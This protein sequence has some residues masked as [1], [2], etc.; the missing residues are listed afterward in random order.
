MM[1]LE[2]IKKLNKQF[3]EDNCIA[4]KYYGTELLTKNGK[5]IGVD[6]M[7][8]DEGLELQISKVI[9][10]NMEDKMWETFAFEDININKFENDYELDKYLEYIIDIY[11]HRFKDDIDEEGFV[12][13]REVAKSIGGMIYK[14]IYVQYLEDTNTLIFTI[15]NEDNTYDDSDDIDT[16]VYRNYT[17]KEIEKHID[18]LINT[19]IREEKV[20]K[21]YHLKN[22]YNDHDEYTTDE[23]KILMIYIDELAQCVDNH[24]TTN[25]FG[26]YEYK[27]A[28]G[29]LYEIMILCGKYNRGEINI[30]EIIEKLNKEH[31]WCI[32]VEIKRGEE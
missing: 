3:I 18:S 24:L 1:T 25:N 7:L 10:V 15:H 29:W 27:N 26:E 31:N 11:E 23:N 9:A 8:S 12:I 30:N 16:I 17:Q 6:L 19:L 28:T 13:N 14:G 2:E 22:T 21:I 20:E 32:E 5:H 4:T